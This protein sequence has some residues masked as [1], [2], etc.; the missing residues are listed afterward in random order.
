MPTIPITHMIAQLGGF[1]VS[2][3]AAQRLNEAD[4]MACLERHLIGDYGDVDDIDWKT[5]NLAWEYG[6]PIVSSYIDRKKNRFL[7]ITEGNRS[8]TTI[9]LPEEY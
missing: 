6:F 4:A 5:N 2:R 9:L 8:A 7:I 1:F 3:K